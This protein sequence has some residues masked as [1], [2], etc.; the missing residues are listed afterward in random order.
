MG[1]SDGKVRIFDLRKRDC[2]S[3]W[4]LK[5]TASETTSSILTLQM[6]S[7]E[8]SI[9]A[10]SSDGQF[11]AWS[12]IQTSQKMFEVQ[13]NDPYFSSDAYPR[14]AWGKQFAFAGD[15][16]HLLVCSSNGGVI[17]EMDDSWPEVDM[18]SHHLITQLPVPVPIIK[19]SSKSL[20]LK[21]TKNML[22][23]QIGRQVTIVG[24]ALQRD[25][26]DKFEFL[27]C[28][29]NDMKKKDLKYILNEI[30]K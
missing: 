13:L 10:L 17:Y 25:L 1:N 14:A 28:L 3:S 19:I 16:R 5:A 30:A 9:Y 24:L 15:G 21:A 22:L 2:I 7:D 6:S 8:T 20:V 18:A 26:T 23:V 4:S 29:V 12:F 11:S 27:L